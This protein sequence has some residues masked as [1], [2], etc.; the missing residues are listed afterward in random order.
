MSQELLINV[1]EFETRVALL[2]NGLLQELHL[3]GSER[4]SYTGN[5]YKGRVQRILPGMQAAFL[6]IGL[7]RP[8]FLHV[9]DIALPRFMAEQNGASDQSPTEVDIRD[10]LHEGQSLLVQIAKDAISSKGAKLTS[11]LALATRTLVML[12]CSS[13]I[14]ISQRIEG[15][16]ERDRLR[17][18]ISGLRDEL[19]GSHEFGFIAR[20]VAE[21][22]EGEVLA[23]DMRVLLRMWQLLVK[24]QHNQS[25]PFLAYEELPMHIRIVRDLA[26]ASVTQ[27]KIDDAETFRRVRRFVDRYVP[28]FTDRL[29]HYN[30]EY[31][32]FE[33]YGIEDEL[34]RALHRKVDLKSGGYLIIEQTE[35]MVTIDVNTGGFV[36]SSNLEETVYRTNLEAAAMIPRQLRLRNLGGIIVIDFIDME[37]EEHR[38]QVLRGLEKALEGDPAKVRVGDFSALG[39]VEMSRKRTRESLLQQLHESCS[40]CSGSGWVKTAESVCHDIFR[41]LSNRRMQEE[42]DGISHQSEYQ[43]RASQEVIDHLLDEQA[44]QLAC[45]RDKSGLSLQLRVEPSYGREQFDIVSSK[46]VGSCSNDQ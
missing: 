13:H 34:Q 10:L 29:S 5:I 1:T 39:L 14:G 40:E 9:S 11:N 18:L 26:S 2:S 31:P 23:S 32:L 25:V 7:E 43:V 36:G 46:L 20:T 27:V 41:E 12:P 45:L 44:K 37:E 19:T 42:G 17:E 33:R 3:Q 21:G 24:Q 28:E 16:E 22:V 35:A 15:D 6:D 38:R 4:Y 30:E 8:G